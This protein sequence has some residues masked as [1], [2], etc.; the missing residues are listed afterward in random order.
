MTIPQPVPEPV[1]LDRTMGDETGMIIPAHGEALREEGAPWLTAAFRRFGS[2]APDNAV[3]RIVRL[4]RCPGGS[5]GA[6]FFLDVAY[7]KPQPAL[8]TALFVKFSRDF[9][10]FRRDHPGRYEMAAE[11]AFMALARDPGFPVA[12]AR[13]FFADYEMETGTGL[14]ITERIAFGEG[15][16][17]A[18]RAKCLDFL[19]MDDPIPYYRAT[20]TA[21]ARLA[22][23]HKSG[24]LSPDIEVLFPWDPVAGSADPIRHDRPALEAELDHCR[25]FVLRCPQHFPAEVR[26]GAFLDR[27]RSEALSIREHEAVLQRF[28]TGDPAMIALNHWNAHIDNCFFWHEG[29]V[30]RCGLIDWGRGGQITFGATLWGALS[31]AHHDIWD[32]HLDALLALFVE[33]YRRAGGPAITTEALENHLMV[34]IATMGV[35]RVLA[36]PEIIEFRLPGIGEAS[37]PHDPAILAIDP[38]RNCLHVLT[39]FLKLWERRDFGRRIRALL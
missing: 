1:R 33:E 4:E 34:H 19:T 37:G 22:G 39:V 2:L 17:E 25:Q 36:F 15:V 7:E 18:H 3:A 13:P 5:T 26:S 12:V 24:R 16:I 11:V 21:L 10:D 23:A 31:A 28:L 29:S 30:L 32:V 8:P 35:A 38:A 27:M 20:V 14:V 6:K 9:A